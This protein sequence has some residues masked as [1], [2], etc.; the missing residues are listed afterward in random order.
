MKDNELP[1]IHGKA[2]EIAA[3]RFERF[4]NLPHLRIRRHAGTGM[5]SVSAL[6]DDCENGM[7]RMVR[8][9]PPNPTYR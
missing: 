3:E 6:P 7:L 9:V 5:F 4:G 8:E 1:K 2:V